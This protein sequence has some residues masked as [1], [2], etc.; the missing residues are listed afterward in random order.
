MA[1]AT[2][3]NVFKCAGVEIDWL[4][5]T[6]NKM[7]E[8]CRTARGAEGRIPRILPPEMAA[9]VSASGIEFGRAQLEPDGSRG[10]FASVYWARV[11]ALAAGE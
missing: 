4:N 11:Q 1:T 5:C 10:T 6:P 7:D 9:N 3:G 8:R 2:A